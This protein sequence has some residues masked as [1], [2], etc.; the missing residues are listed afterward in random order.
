MYS[1]T[2]VL[3]AFEDFFSNEGYSWDEFEYTKQAVISIEGTDVPVKFVEGE[4]GGEGSGEYCYVILR[5]GE[6]YFRKEGYY[7]SYNGTDWDGDFDEVEPYQK[8]ITDYKV[9]S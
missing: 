5:V 6:Q 4:T 8:T 1:K 2:E 9:K 7:S 3:G